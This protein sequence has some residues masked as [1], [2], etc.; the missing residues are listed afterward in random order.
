ML[1]HSKDEA[2]MLEC[3]FHKWSASLGALPE[4]IYRKDPR[5]RR[6]LREQ[7]TFV[8]KSK[9]PD[10]RSDQVLSGTT[11][12]FSSPSTYSD[13]DSILWLAGFAGPEKLHVEDWAISSDE[14]GVTGYPVQKCATAGARHELVSLPPGHQEQGIFPRADGK[15]H[16]FPSI[17]GVPVLGSATLARASALKEMH[18]PLPAA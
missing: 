16:D 9:P 8:L 12:R 11:A 4:E 1:V 13:V 18:R 17:Q 15:R 7:A 14:P 3:F 6:L 2:R 5:K 10:E